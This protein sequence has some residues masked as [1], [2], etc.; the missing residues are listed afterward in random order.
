MEKNMETTTMGY[1][2]TSI[3]LTGVRTL[4]S[5]VPQTLNPTIH[6]R[7]AKSLPF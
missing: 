3:L 7:E 5:G 4:T 1:I 6:T 2:G